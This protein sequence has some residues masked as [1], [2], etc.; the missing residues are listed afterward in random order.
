MQSKK[1]L[2]QITK[3]RKL[4]RLLIWETE[5][6]WYEKH[7]NRWPPR[8][9]PK[10][11]CSLTHPTFPTRPY[12]KLGLADYMGLKPVRSCSCQFGSTANHET[13]C[14]PFIPPPC[15]SIPGPHRLGYSRILEFTRAILCSYQSHQQT[16]S[17]TW[18]YAI[19]CGMHRWHEGGPAGHWAKS[20]EVNTLDRGR[21]KCFQ[22]PQ[23]CLA[24][25]CITT[26][27]EKKQQLIEQHGLG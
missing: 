9:P 5:I 22:S 27:P 19:T 8:H 15:L 6:A 12:D 24:H 25:R 3:R 14:E 21:K 17:V 23:F 2:S 10:Q 7:F 18:R 16:D 20:R 4:N 11:G 13:C 1:S 26:G